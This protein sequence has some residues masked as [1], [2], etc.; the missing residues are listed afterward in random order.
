MSTG[1]SLLRPR[2]GARFVGWD[3][4]NVTHDDYIRCPVDPGHPGIG[5]T[6]SNDL[7]VIL[8]SSKLDDILCTWHAEYIITEQ[9]ANLFQ[10]SRLTGYELRP[11]RVTAVMR[12][13]KNIVNLPKLWELKITGWAGFASKES[14]IRLEQQCSSCGY[15]H[16]SPPKDPGRIVDPRQWDGSDF[17]IVW[18]MPGFV[19]VTDRAKSVAV[20][21]KLR[22]VKFVAPNAVEFHPAGFSPGR[23][24][25]YMD[26]ERAKKLG[27]PLGIE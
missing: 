16:Y 8:P 26:Q 19:F 13:D 12:G 21:H 7:H 11:V 2:D 10:A 1:T 25:Y 5:R 17:F 9:V 22:G 6:R 27:G 18:P 4:L 15:A 3:P 23:L 14:G 20:E 24:W